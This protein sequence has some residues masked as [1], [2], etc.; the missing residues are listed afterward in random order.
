M[1]WV[2]KLWSAVSLGTLQRSWASAPPCQER[3]MGRWRAPQPHGAP[4]GHLSRNLAGPLLGVDLLWTPVC[5][6]GTQGLLG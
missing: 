6:A 1:G 5:L 4:T 2:G 3:S